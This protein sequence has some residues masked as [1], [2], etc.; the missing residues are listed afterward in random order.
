M[1]TIRVIAFP[2]SVTIFKPILLFDMPLTRTRKILSLI[3]ITAS[4]REDLRSTLKQLNPAS[5]ALAT[6]KNCATSPSFAF[7]TPGLVMIIFFVKP[8][9]KAR[10]K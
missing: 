9:E 1:I 7:V 4:Y 10:Y 6:N 8:F 2:T 3:T 5:I